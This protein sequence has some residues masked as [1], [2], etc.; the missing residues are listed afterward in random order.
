MRK[1]WLIY[2]ALFVWRF[3]GR[4]QAK[5]AV[6]FDQRGAAIAS[7]LLVRLRTTGR[8]RAGRVDLQW[9]ALRL[10]AGRG[11]LGAA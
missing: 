8:R 2:L 11:A 1:F 10:P 9:R 4:A 7:E 3:P 6:Q 5:A